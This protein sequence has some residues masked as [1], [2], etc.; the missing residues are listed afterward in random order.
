[1]QTMLGGEH[2]VILEPDKYAFLD[3]RDAN[4]LSTRLNQTQNDDADC[5]KPILASTCQIGQKLFL[6]EWTD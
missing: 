5:A 1:M 3:G 4:A 6:R 2:S